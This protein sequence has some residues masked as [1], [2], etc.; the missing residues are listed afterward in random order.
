MSKKLFLER[1]YASVVREEDPEASEGENQGGPGEPL[2]SPWFGGF[3]Y[4]KIR[5]VSWLL[6]ILLFYYANAD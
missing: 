4:H 3:R 1:S 2:I 5:Y 6:I